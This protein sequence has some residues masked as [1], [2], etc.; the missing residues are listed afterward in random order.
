MTFVDLLAL[1]LATG[2]PINAWL[3]VG[4]IFDNWREYVITWG[5]DLRDHT[6][7][8]ELVPALT[9]G[10]RIRLLIGQLAACRFCLHYHAALWLV[11]LYA[12][13]IFLE[14]PWSIVLRLP[15]Y[16]L[17]AV[18][19]SYWCAVLMQEGWQDRDEE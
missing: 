14:Q 3:R 18:R 9:Y 1:V 4:G 11:V 2:A 6:M 12:G 10:D 15:I 17:A 19:A 7:P 8:A 5:A 16:W 13:S